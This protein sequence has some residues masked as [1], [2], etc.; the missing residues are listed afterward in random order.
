MNTQIHRLIPR[1]LAVA[2]L[3]LAPLPAAAQDVVANPTSYDFFTVYIG[4]SATMT[5]CLTNADA[6]PLPLLP[7]SA[8]TTRSGL[9]R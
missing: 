1:W 8:R 9:S 6:G 3:L 4:N 7:G 5:G 2:G